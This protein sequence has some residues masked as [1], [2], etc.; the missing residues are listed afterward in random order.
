MRIVLKRAQHFITCDG[1]FY[2]LDDP[3]QVKFRLILAEQTDAGE[4]LTLFDKLTTASPTEATIALLQ[5]EK[6][7]K[8]LLQST[9]A[10]GISVL[11]GQL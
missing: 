1:K 5:S 2:G 10:T 11:T 4:Q 8:F 9:P 7:E 3:E 6:R